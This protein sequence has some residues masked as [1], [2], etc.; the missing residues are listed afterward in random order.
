[1]VST[2]Q[3]LRVTGLPSKTQQSDVRQFFT[4]RIKRN[5]G[6]QIV[7]FV[8]TICGHASRSTKRTTVSFSSY[9]T[10]QKAL[11]LG[12]TSRLFKADNGGAETITLDAS[13]LDLTTLHS[14]NNPA[15][16]KPDVEYVLDMFIVPPS[17][18]NHIPNNTQANL[19]LLEAS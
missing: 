17:T 5:H 6:R 14:S 4:E 1:M 13:F 2:Q 19:D 11:N 16:G 12:E 9:K 7:E 18:T 15:T 10:A 3:T 8:G